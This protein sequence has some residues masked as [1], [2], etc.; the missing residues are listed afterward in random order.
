MDRGGQDASNY[1]NSANYRYQEDI[2]EQERV[3]KVGWRSAIRILKKLFFRLKFDFLSDLN[4][5]IP[6][7]N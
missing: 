6:N 4:S 7:T 5:S 1:T 2:N 3:E